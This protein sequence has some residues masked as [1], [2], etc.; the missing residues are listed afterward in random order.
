M[1][2]GRE[3]ERAFV[4]IVV[5]EV[6]AGSPR[7]L[8]VRGE[9]GVGKSALL[10]HLV[11]TAGAAGFTVPSGSAGLSFDTTSAPRDGAVLLVLDD[12][13]LAD[14]A[15]V[16]ALDLLLREGMSGSVLLAV[17]LRPRD[18]LPALLAVLDEAAVRGGL[19][20][21]ELGPLSE[22][23]SA[24]LIAGTVVDI[25]ERDRIVAESSGNPASLLRLAAPRPSRGSGPPGGCAS[26][27]SSP[28]PADCTGRW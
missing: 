4:D 10:S 23:E 28:V 14:P 26:L 12:A 17:A 18:A 21:I 5:T 15:T 13:H 25:A 22:D 6:A 20:V 2:I 11:D 16:E 27:S 3:V 1:I 24:A 8:V 7:T 9:P 19:D